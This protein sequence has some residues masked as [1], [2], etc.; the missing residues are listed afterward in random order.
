MMQKD[1]C[2]FIFDSIAT[3]KLFVFKITMRMNWI[4]KLVLD[5][6]SFKYVKYKCNALYC[7]QLCL[8]KSMRTAARKV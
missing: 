8:W 5:F 1:S 3:L 4:L 2:H 6:W 7:P